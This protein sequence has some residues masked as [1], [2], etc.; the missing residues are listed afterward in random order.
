MFL[1]IQTSRSTESFS[2]RTQR[3][4]QLLDSADAVVIGAGAGLSVSAGF[5][6]S[7]DRFA[8]YFGDFRRKYG[9]Q[10]MYSGGFCFFETPEE[11]WAYWS[12][13]IWINRYEDPP[14]PVY[15]VL[16]KLVERRDYFV[17]TTNVD[18]CFQRAGFEKE[19]LFYTQGDYG[20]WQCAEPCHQRTYDNETAVRRMVLEQRDMRIPSALIP[21]CPRCGRPM[22][23]NLRTDEAFVQDEGW[24]AA[25]GRY[26]EFMR[27]HREGAVLYL[28]L[29]VGQNTPG[30]IKYPFWQQV[31]QNPKAGYV[32]I[33][34]GQAYAPR[35]IEERSLC[36]DADIGAVL[37]AL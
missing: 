18:H 12:R 9:F 11:Q 20:L 1:Q 19:R 36:I 23:M 13:Y 6:Y 33:N 15:D 37:A 27:R 35:E 30:I 4:R 28:E 34:R 22:C 29:G 10:D 2:A 17:L 21:R 5:T 3:L 24:Y 32:C 26:E 14:E 7:G 31:L 25:A 8:R 16:R